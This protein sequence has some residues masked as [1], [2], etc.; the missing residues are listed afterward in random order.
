MREFAKGVVAWDQWKD[1]PFRA[2]GATTFNVITL[3]AGPLGA[4][5]KGG[6]AAA[7]AAGAAAKAGTYADPLSAAITAGGKAASKLPK[8]SE[9]ATRV[10]GGGV[11]SVL[12]FKG[13]SK[14]RVDDG[15]F[16]V[17][18]NGA[19]EDG[20]IPHEP[21][22]AERATAPEPARHY[23]LTGA[24]ARGAEGPPGRDGA[25]TPHASHEPPAGRGG[26]AHSAHGQGHDGTGGGT[27][28]ARDPHD[29]GQ[30]GPFDSA[31]NGGRPPSGGAG[32]GGAG[33]GTDA[34]TDPGGGPGRTER[35]AFMHDGDN[36]YGSRGSLTREQIEE[37]QVYRANNEPGYFER[38]YQGGE[39]LGARKDLKA[40]DES[41]F[42]PPQLT[43]LSEG[44][45]LIR[46]KD[47]PEPPAP[48]FLDDDYIPVRADSVT[49]PARLKILHKAAQD[50]HLAILWDKLMENMRAETGKAHK[51]HGTL[52]TRGLWGEA[53]GAYRESHTQMGD[54]AEEFG[55]KVAEYHFIAER[56]P[57]FE[58]QPLLGPKN[59]NDQFDQ[60]WMHEDG[61]VVVIEAKS[62]VDTQLGH[63]TLPKGN[64]VSQGS[65][66]YFVDIIRMMKRRGE[67]RVVSALERALA[68]GKLEYIVVKGERNAGT[69]TGL[70]YRRFDISKGTL[71]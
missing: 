39:H 28:G 13:I 6:S 48:H 7:K 2:A 45:P 3:G 67:I 44:G 41:G 30:S 36:P 58:R 29:P 27:A 60:V 4:V 32:S 56:Y 10:G 57:N 52:E 19:P 38:Y 1:N 47:S 63:R 59:G 35:P 49:S 71:S 18:K 20:P 69:Y 22:A 23:E 61:R 68:E 24:G 17:T 15:E 53:K 42:T 65:R 46:A 16:L 37:I 5:S 33:R 43:R 11:H 26:A 8:V 40:T 51:T 9:L 34:S 50:R 62:S 54:L 55:E 12:D 25:L 14:V 21:S 66:E 31:S 70:Q 64:R